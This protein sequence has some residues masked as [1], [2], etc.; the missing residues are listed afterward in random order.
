MMKVLGEYPIS[1]AGRIAVVLLTELGLYGFGPD[2]ASLTELL[3][4]LEKFRSASPSD[5]G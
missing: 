1:V 4:I 2:L 5:R 3:R